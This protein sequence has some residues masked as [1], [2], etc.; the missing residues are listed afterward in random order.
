MQGD[1]T[2]TRLDLSAINAR[3]DT[4]HDR[5]ADD[6][7]DEGCRVLARSAF[8]DVPALLAEVE[9][10]RDGIR[11]LV[12]DYTAPAHWR[13]SEEMAVPTSRLRDLLD[14]RT[15]HHHG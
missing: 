7:T 11:G 2:S 13:L 14:D 12:A 10:L 8:R 3:W 1:T 15:E 5:D 4:S 6:Y 9:R